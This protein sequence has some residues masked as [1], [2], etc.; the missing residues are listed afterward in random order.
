MVAY[1]II[2]LATEARL[3]HELVWFVFE[4]LERVLHVCKQ[5][6]ISLLTMQSNEPAESAW[7]RWKALKAW[8]CDVK[9]VAC[10]DG[11][12]GSEVERRVTQSGDES[13]VVAEGWSCVQWK[14]HPDVLRDVHLSYLR[15]GAEIIIAN[16]YA[17]NRHIM[18][19]AGY[20][21]D[22]V[23]ATRAAVRLALEAR[24]RHA[25]ETPQEASDFEPLVAGSM[26]CHPPGMAHGASMDMGK[27]P[28]PAVEEQG[29]R[30]QAQILK[31]AGA[32]IIFVEMVWHWRRHGKLAVQAADSVG[33]PVAV[34]LA[35]F[36]SG[37]CSEGM[38][39]LSDGTL[40]EEVAKDIASGRCANVD[41]ICIHHTKLPLVLPCLKALRKGGWTGPLGCYPDH[42]T[43]K[44]PHWCFDPLASEYL[45]GLATEWVA[46]TDCSLLGGCCGIGPESIKDLSNW[47]CK[48]NAK[49]RCNKAG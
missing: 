1:P 3:I 20:E 8:R 30:E 36:D 23:K 42:G 24:S 22:T 21:H 26:S 34:C 39:C 16:S 45:C 43:F 6:L 15:S 49:C 11:G 38:P 47:C 14:T 35:V 40:V 28:E 25:A 9:G 33:L 44:M 17:T 32:D 2:Y 13:A 41:C 10:I 46:E 5:K 29:Y 18:K 48:Y 31:D 4:L 37:G 19:A 12:T 27:W 7:A